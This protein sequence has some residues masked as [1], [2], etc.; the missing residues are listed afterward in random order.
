MWEA[1][2]IVAVSLL[3]FCC[4][5]AVVMAALRL[6]GTWLILAA[7]LVY[8]WWADWEGVSLWLVL[9]LVI[10][11]V[12]AEVFE[13]LASALTARRA[14]ASRQAAWGGLIGGFLGMFLLSFLVPI[15]VVGTVIGA[16]LG[17]FIGATIAELNVRRHIGQGTK[18][19]LFSALGFVVGMVA[20]TAMALAMA[21]ILLTS[22]VFTESRSAKPD[23]PPTAEEEKSLIVE[24]PHEAPGT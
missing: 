16:L 22:V 21:G 3:G 7:A 20:K 17:C 6:P 9:G 19:G 18:V 1:W 23:A 5:I 2:T 14:G 12:V 24:D 10:I 4:L 8:G 11:A 15:P 13:F